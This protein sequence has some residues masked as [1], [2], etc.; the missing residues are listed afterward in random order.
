MSTELT[1]GPYVLDVQRG[2]L[3]RE[4]RPVALSSKG[5][6]LLE[7]FLAAPGQVLTKPELMRKAWG[8][9]TVEESNLSVQIAALRKQLGPAADGTDWIATIPRVGY[10]F[11]GPP[12]LAPI[13]QPDE[14][15]PAPQGERRP[16]IAVLPF[17]NLSEEK[18]A[19]VS[20]GW[21]H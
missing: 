16:S 5:F 11:A 19:G 1:F 17:A 3:L 4:G 15:K 21:D 10:R 13:K 9:A 2:V 14:T 7:A 20:R 18:R 12:E 6:R 8:D